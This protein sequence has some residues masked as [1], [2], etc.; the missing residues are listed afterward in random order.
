MR[1]ITANN[2]NG[3]W[4]TALALMA[5]EGVKSPSRNGE[6]SVHPYPVVTCY[7][8]P[9]ERVLFDPIRDANP[10]FHLHEA[11]W[12][13]AGRD[14]ATWLDQ[15]V[16]DFSKR[17]A[18]DGGKMHGAYG[19]RWRDWFASDEDP[20]SE[21]YPKI[22]QLL[23]VIELL[24]KNPADRQAVIQMW[25]AEM[26]LG[27]P[28]LKDRPCNQQVLLRADRGVL[29]ITVTCRSND[30]VY[31][32]YGANAVH[33]SV[34]QEYLAAMIGIP[35]GRYFQVSNNFHIYDWSHK[36][37][38]IQDAVASAIYDTHYPTMQ[39]LVDDPASFD[40]EVR[41]YVEYP[42]DSILVAGMKNTF[43]HCTAHPMFMANR[44]RRLGELD[45]A[46]EYARGIQAD[47]WRQACIEWL[48]RRK[49]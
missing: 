34:L 30:V 35:V 17:F 14:D 13:L 5:A 27:V 48:M 46:L 36:N 33:F 26:D 2:V 8:R 1:V 18:E 15:F 16:G 45:A 24:K 39:P 29:D 41:M 22:D 28:N 44:M 47:D 11:L 25:D 19:K 49:K 9:L 43:L 4:P 23:V 31:G 37:I 38:K 21:T 7:E 10:F 42:H 40:E 32:C 6:V 20:A 3:A 12:M